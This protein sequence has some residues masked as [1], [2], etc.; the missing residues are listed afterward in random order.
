MEKINIKNVDEARQFVGRR[1]R[2]FWFDGSEYAPR[3]EG[4]LRIGRAYGSDW[5]GVGKSGPCG[6]GSTAVSMNSE[7]DAWIELL[8]AHPD[9]ARYAAMVGKRIKVVAA[10]GSDDYARFSARLAGGIVTAVDTTGLA[11][12]VAVTWLTDSGDSHMCYIG[13]GFW[14]DVVID[15]PPTLA[16]QLET[17][18]AE[19]ARIEA[20]IAR[21]ATEAAEQKARAEHEAEDARYPLP[22]GWRWERN[23]NGLG[24]CAVG[25]NSRLEYPRTLCVRVLGGMS[26]EIVTRGVD[27]DIGWERPPLDVVRAVIARYDAERAKDAPYSI[28]LPPGGWCR[29]V[30]HTFQVKDVID[31]TFQSGRVERCVISKVDDER[32]IWVKDPYTADRGYESRYVGNYNGRGV[33]K[34]TLVSRGAQ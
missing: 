6:C 17:A 30:P 20:E 27:C 9:A 24:L 28:D 7:S 3:G 5:V 16:D 13:P 10:G 22:E 14:P 34:V 1:V 18:R 26:A 32:D 11:Q 25:P 4:L 19:V 15:E 31:L 12:A 23:Y 8:D 2:L 21:E 33:T 29:D